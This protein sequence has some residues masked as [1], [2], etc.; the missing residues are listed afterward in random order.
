MHY[1]FQ[2]LLCSF[3]DYEDIAGAVKLKN[4]L[5]KQTNACHNILGGC[6]IKINEKAIMATNSSSRVRFIT[7]LFTP[8]K[9]KKN[10]AFVDLK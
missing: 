3:K 7:F 10:L 9:K 1:S 6:A 2:R 4:V 8:W 5:I